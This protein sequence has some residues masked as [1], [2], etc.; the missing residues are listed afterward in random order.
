MPNL[1]EELDYSINHVTLIRN[2]DNMGGCGSMATLHVFDI[3]MER[4]APYTPDGSYAFNS[5][6]YND[7]MGNHLPRPRDLRIKKHGLDQIGVIMKYGCCPETTFPT[8]YDPPRQVFPN[9]PIPSNEAFLHANKYKIS[10]CKRS[11][12][13]SSI[14]ELKKLLYERGPL[15]FN[16]NPVGSPPGEGHVIALIGYNDNT[17]MIKYINSARGVFNGIQEQ[18]YDILRALARSRSCEASGC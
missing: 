6:V 13:P 2:Q 7:S 9:E 17:Q 10:D 3:Q 11:L 8:I 1:P 12:H 5:Y 15:V 4:L 16:H 14:D 18:S